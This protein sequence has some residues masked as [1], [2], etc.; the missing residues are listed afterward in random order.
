MICSA[1]TKRELLYSG[2]MGGEQGSKEVRGREQ[3]PRA[4]GKCLGGGRKAAEP[5]LEREGEAD[6]AEGGWAGSQG[7]PEM[8][9]HCVPPSLGTACLGPCSERGAGP[10]LQGL[11]PRPQPPCFSCKAACIPPPDALTHLDSSES[12]SP[13]EAMRKV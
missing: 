13:A 9:G 11:L 7:Q 6:E 2:F 5:S 8:V 12:A 10:E 4:G 1:P 3:S